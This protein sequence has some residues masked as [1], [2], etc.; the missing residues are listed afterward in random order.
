MWNDQQETELRLTADGT[1]AVALATNAFSFA[2]LKELCLSA[3][4]AWM[5][6]G[7]KTPM[8]EVAT[9]QTEILRALWK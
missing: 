6:A 8:D 3:T 1:H 9:A 4:M 2:Y 7:G 5:N